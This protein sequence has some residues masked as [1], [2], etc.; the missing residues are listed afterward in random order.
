MKYAL[1]H[2]WS[3]IRALR[4]LIGIIIIVQAVMN[5]EWVFGIAGI[6]FACMA[7][8]NQG[9]CGTGACYTPIK[10]EIDSSKAITYEELD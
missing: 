1:L 10:K 6:F 4:L 3:F 8:F 5:K 7:L 2:N 9:C